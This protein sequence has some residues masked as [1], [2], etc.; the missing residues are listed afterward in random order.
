M[1]KKNK[2]LFSAPNF[3][4]FA[5]V[6]LCNTQSQYSVLILSHSRFQEGSRLISLHQVIK[7]PLLM[8]ESCYSQTHSSCWC[9]SKAN[10]RS[11]QS[12]FQHGWERGSRGPTPSWGGPRWL[13]EEGK[14]FF[15]FKGLWPLLSKVTHAPVPGPTFICIWAALIGLRGL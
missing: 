14:S 6:A 2:L 8:T 4:P 1:T 10:T 11:S 3:T 12:T 15:S 7:C 9:L 13:L 5:I